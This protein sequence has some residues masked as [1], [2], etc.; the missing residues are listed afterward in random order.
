MTTLVLVGLGRVE[1]PTSPLSGVRSSHL[2]YRPKR[3]SQRRSQTYK[4]R[5]RVTATQV[6][7]AS[8][9]LA[10]WPFLGACDKKETQG[11]RRV[12]RFSFGVERTFQSFREG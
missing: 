7:S 1:L 6:E 4:Y 5:Q 10:P 11:T 8:G 2:S 12:F 3:A 9:G